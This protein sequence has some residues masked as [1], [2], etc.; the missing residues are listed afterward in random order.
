MCA[1]ACAREGQL[2]VFSQLKNSISYS[3]FSM[4][5]RS[6]RRGIKQ[7]VILVKTTRHFVKMTRRFSENNPL[8]RDVRC[9]FLP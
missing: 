5:I 4:V 6:F 3:L 2:H 1:Y 8:F 7:P 9:F